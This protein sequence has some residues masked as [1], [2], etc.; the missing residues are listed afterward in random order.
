MSKASVLLATAL[1]PITVPPLPLLYT[2]MHRAPCDQGI[3]VKSGNEMFTAGSPLAG[4]SM[5]ENVGKV[6]GCDVW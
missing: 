6:K 3:I 2:L 1:T 5:N 4:S